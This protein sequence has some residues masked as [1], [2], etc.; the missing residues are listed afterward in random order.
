MTMKSFDELK[1]KEALYYG[2]SAFQGALAGGNKAFAVW[3]L[4]DFEEEIFVLTPAPAKLPI[5]LRPSSL[6]LP[7]TIGTGI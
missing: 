1:D 5:T 7:S 4:E 6:R 3:L 2:W